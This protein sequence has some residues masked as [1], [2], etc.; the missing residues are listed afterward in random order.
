MEHKT[1][2]YKLHIRTERHKV[3]VY[4]VWKSPK[5]LAINFVNSYFCQTFFENWTSPCLQVV[6]NPVQRTDTYPTACIVTDSVQNVPCNM[7]MGEWLILWIRWQGG[8]AEVSQWGDTGMVGKVEWDFSKGTGMRNRRIQAEGVLV[9]QCGRF[10]R[11]C[12][13]PNAT[14]PQRQKV[15]N[16]LHPLLG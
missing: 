7:E 9:E 1:V 15:G 14:A 3:R 13:R 5:G 10:L 6:H 12:M 8:L 2:L 11:M 16:P 4:S